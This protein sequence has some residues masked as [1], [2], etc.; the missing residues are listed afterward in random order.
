MTRDLF[1]KLALGR[2]HLEMRLYNSASACPMTL[3]PSSAV[4]S[5]PRLILR[6]ARENP[7]ATISCCQTIRSLG[8]YLARPVRLEA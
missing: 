7:L 5:S 8:L 1:Q 3:Q 6:Y 2:L 4:Y